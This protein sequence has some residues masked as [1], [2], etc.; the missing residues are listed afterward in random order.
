MFFLI[1][2]AALVVIVLI[3]LPETNRERRKDEKDIYS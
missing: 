1:F 3:F 2:Y